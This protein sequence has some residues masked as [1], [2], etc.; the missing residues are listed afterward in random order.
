MGFYAHLSFL[1]GNMR[2][3]LRM[4]QHVCCKGV[5]VYTSRAGNTWADSSGVEHVPVMDRALAQ[6]LGLRKETGGGGKEKRLDCCL[7]IISHLGKSQ[8]LA[9]CHFP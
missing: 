1:M 9:K 7:E 5:C 2:S 6:T 8:F 4:A 3:Q